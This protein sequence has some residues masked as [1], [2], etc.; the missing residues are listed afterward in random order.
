MIFAFVSGLALAGLGSSASSDPENNTGQD[1]A[2]PGTGQPHPG[3]PAE[4]D[5]PLLPG[6]QPTKQGT[7]PTSQVHNVDP[8]DLE[9]KKHKN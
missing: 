7:D 2:L 8:K 6:D 5:K 4:G 9:G 3:N 1:P